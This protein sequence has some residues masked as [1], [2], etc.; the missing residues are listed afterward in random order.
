LNDADSN[1]ELH[2]IGLGASAWTNDAKEREIL[3]NEIEAAW[4]HQSH[5][6]FRS[7]L[8]FGGVKHSG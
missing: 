8:P 4:F 3:I 7:T 5:G 1:R 6:G 2:A